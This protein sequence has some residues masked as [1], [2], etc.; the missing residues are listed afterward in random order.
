MDVK[1]KSNKLKRQEA[2]RKRER[3]AERLALTAA[4]SASA[5]ERR[6]ADQALRESGLSRV[7]TKRMLRMILEGE[8]IPIADGTDLYHIA[9]LLKDVRNRPSRFFD[10]P[11]SGIDALK[12]LLPVCHLRTGFFRRHEASRFADALLALSNHAGRWIRA[13]EDWKPRSHNTQ[14]QLH[15]LARHLLARYDVPTFMNS[16]WMEGTTSRS[17]IHQR[18]FIHVG[19]GQNIRTANGLPVTLTKKQAHFYLQAPDDFDVVRAFR[20]A[21]IIDLGGSDR[22]VRAVLAT[23]LGTNFAH[24]EFWTT[25][26]RWLVAHPMLDPTHIGPI[27]DYLHQHRFVPSVPNPNAHLR[28]EPRLVP[29]QPNLSVKDRTPEALLRSVA[30]WHRELGRERTV[31]ITSWDPSA[32]APF[33]LVERQGDKELVFTITEL[34]SSRELIEE[35]RAMYHCVGSYAHSCASGRR[36]IWSLK[37]VDASGRESRLLTLEVENETRQ[38][39][40]ARGKLNMTLSRD[41][42]A[43][44]RRWK[45]SGGP[46]LSE[47]LAR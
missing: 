6:R 42:W 25:V 32:I 29:R 34:L 22:L 21:Q 13:P 11:Y 37:L 15:S 28:G 46:G 44:L 16:V 30:D 18:W 7:G 31:P 20:W 12:R 41:H 5:N 38:I 8:D 45:D 14:W 39:V 43:I 19:Q 40:Q 35:G 26:F 17:A 23:R 33:R 36:S 47:W 1:P 24:D 27:I 3:R 2:E 9:R 10:L 4:R